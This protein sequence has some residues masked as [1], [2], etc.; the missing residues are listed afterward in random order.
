MAGNTHDIDASVSEVRMTYPVHYIRF[1]VTN[2][3][4]FRVSSMMIKRY[5]HEELSDSKMPMLEGSRCHELANHLVGVKL[6]FTEFKSEA[7]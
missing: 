4:G 2:K 6:A 1:T 5:E 3:F 7:A